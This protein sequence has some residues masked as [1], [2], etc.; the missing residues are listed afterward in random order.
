MSPKK[1]RGNKHPS[2]EPTTAAAATPPPPPPDDSS[3]KKQPQK[4]LPVI[5]EK[6]EHTA[7][8]AKKRSYTLVFIIGGLVGLFLAV[9]FAKSQD[10]V[11][12]DFQLGSLVDVIPA[13]ILKEAT[14]ISVCRPRSRCR[15]HGGIGND[16]ASAM[17]IVLTHGRQQREKDVVSADAFRV[18]LAL[19]SEGLEANHPVIMVGDHSFS[20]GVKLC[21]LME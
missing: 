6:V 5:V 9:F 10:I 7:K 8:R 18:G 4:T 12:G 13:G 3:S 2:S 20:A 16:N 21:V 11:I 14:D 15:L 19:K 17:P 1:R